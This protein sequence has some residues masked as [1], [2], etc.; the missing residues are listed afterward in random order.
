[1]LYTL[2]KKTKLS[3]FGEQNIFDVKKMHGRG[4][5]VLSM[6]FIFS[7]I[8]KRS[9]QPRSHSTCKEDACT[10]LITTNMRYL[11]PFRSAWIYLGFYDTRVNKMDPM[12]R[13][14]QVP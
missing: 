5:K 4:Q 1:M 12:L 7:L 9:T 13:L 11:T 14:L 10:S 8:F 6:E 3:E 2:S